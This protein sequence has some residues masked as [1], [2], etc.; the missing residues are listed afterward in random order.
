MKYTELGD[1]IDLNEK[2]IRRTVKGETDPKIETAVRICFGLNLPPVLSEKL[3]EV[4]NCKLSPV[5][6]KHQWIKEALCLKYPESFDE[7]CRWLRE[8]DVEI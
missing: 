4:L 2:T 5:N 8:Y 3:L 1:A 6:Q 7:V